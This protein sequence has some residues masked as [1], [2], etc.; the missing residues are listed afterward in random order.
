MSVETKQADAAADDYVPF[1]T[2]VA[3]AED[4][5]PTNAQIEKIKEANE[6]F[7]QGQQ[8]KAAEIL[9]LADVGMVVNAAFLPINGSVTH[10][11]DAARLIA[12]GSYYEANLALK[13]VEDSAVLETYT[14]EA[15][16]AQGNKTG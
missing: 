3:L 8:K 9:K 11:D 14:A 5:K 16:P 12:E 7:A 1:D 13:A 2:S 4:F 15:I 6:H 10:V